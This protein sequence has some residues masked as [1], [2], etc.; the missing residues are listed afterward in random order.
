[1]YW[2]KNDN[3][4][5]VL[6]GQQRTISLCEYYKNNFSVNKKLFTNL[7]E[8]DQNKFLNY[9]LDIHICEGAANEKLAWFNR[10]NIADA[11]LTDQELRNAAY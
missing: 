8:E 6:D 11:T 4:Y 5:E 2:A 3:G 9:E 7:S 10:V 1:M